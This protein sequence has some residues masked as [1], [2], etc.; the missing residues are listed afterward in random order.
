[1]TELQALENAVKSVELN[2][3]QVHEYAQTDKR[4]TIKLYFL[5]HFGSTISPRLDYENMNHF[6]LGLRRGLDIVSTLIKLPKNN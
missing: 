1:M 4:K 3:L 2:G 5:N 6:I